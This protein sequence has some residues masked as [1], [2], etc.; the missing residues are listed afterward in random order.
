[1]YQRDGRDLRDSPERTEKVEL[2]IREREDFR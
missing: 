2:G 1:M